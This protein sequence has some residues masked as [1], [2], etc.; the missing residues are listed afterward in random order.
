MARKERLDGLSSKAATA[1]RHK[2]KTVRP[3]FDHLEFMSN[4]TEWPCFPI[5][6]IKNLGRRQASGFPELGFILADETPIQVHKPTLFGETE[7]A[8]AQKTYQSLDELVAD[9]WIVD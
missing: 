8:G 1:A 3:V 4:P 2:R 9:G 7:E 5:L 6:P